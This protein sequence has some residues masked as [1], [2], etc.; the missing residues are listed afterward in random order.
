MDRRYP[1]G[2]S[3]LLC[4]WTNKFVS[5]GV[6]AFFHK[7]PVFEP[8]IYSEDCATK[9]G[10]MAKFKG[11]LPFQKLYKSLGCWAAY[12]VLCRT[13]ECPSVFSAVYQGFSELIP[14]CMRDTPP[15]TSLAFS[16]QLWKLGRHLMQPF[17]FLSTPPPH[18]MDCLSTVLVVVL[19]Y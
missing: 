12:T 1:A 15:W 4:I 14:I 18:Y 7:P 10:W 8:S 19:C 2:I 6:L 3:D 13:S 9:P 11:Q 16:F 5:Y 17:L